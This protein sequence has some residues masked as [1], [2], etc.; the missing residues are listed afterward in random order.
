[1][2]TLRLLMAGL[3][4]EV[5]CVS[6]VTLSSQF[7]RSD[8]WYV[9]SKLDMSFV[10]DSSKSGSPKSICTYH[11]LDFLRCCHRKLDQYFKIAIL[12][13]LVVF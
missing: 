1:M 5:E 4:S 8:L 9:L 12:E 3:G 6:T 13:V 11:Y 7:S 10:S 2:S